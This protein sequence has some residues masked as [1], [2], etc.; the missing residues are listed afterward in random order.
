M[1]RRPLLTLE[2]LP[3]MP[4]KDGVR[5]ECARRLQLG[6]EVP[7]LARLTSLSP[8]ALADS[9]RRSNSQGARNGAKSP[10]DGGRS[11]SIW[12]ISVGMTVAVQ[13]WYPSD[14]M[15]S[16]RPVSRADRLGAYEV[17]K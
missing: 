6:A 8:G 14:L 2:R 7:W 3:L 15:R 16:A 17:L 10:Q 4:V 12:E 1:R 5:P 9:E 11:S 13:P